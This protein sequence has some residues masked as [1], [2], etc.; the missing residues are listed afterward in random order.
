[1]AEKNKRES[2]ENEPEEK[3]RKKPKP[4]KE[5]RK[6]AGKF[7]NAK[8]EKD[9]EETELSMGEGTEIPESERKLAE[10][11]TKKTEK[12]LEK[13]TQEEINGT[14]IELN[15]AYKEPGMT[16]EGKESILEYSMPDTHTEKE[17]EVS[18]EAEEKQEQP[19]ASVTSSDIKEPSGGSEETEPEDLLKEMEEKGMISRSGD[20]LQSMQDRGDLIEKG[21]AFE[22]LKRAGGAGLA[23]E[24]LMESAEREFKAQIYASNEKRKER[25]MKELLPVEIQGENIK[26]LMLKLGYRFAPPDKGFEKRGF[27]R[28]I[29]IGWEKLFMLKLEIADKD[30]NRVIDPETKRPKLIENSMG[31]IKDRKGLIEF[32]KKE[33]EKKGEESSDLLEKM[34]ATGQIIERDGRIIEEGPITFGYAKE[35]QEPSEVVK[36]VTPEEAKETTEITEITGETPLEEKSQPDDEKKYKE[37]YDYMNSFSR[38]N[39]GKNEKDW[40]F[41]DA[42]VGLEKGDPKP[43]RKKLEEMKKINEKIL[44][45]AEKKNDAKLVSEREKNIEKLTKL[46]SELG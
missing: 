35:G 41:K 23:S 1:M 28:K 38:M 45:D 9:Y 32:L 40:E 25:K 30:G 21:D 26:F 7:K 44:K 17:E 11:N 10:E 4:K 31:G 3:P 34:K 46:L 13:E 6:E 14:I 22:S 27:F 42:L 33:Y 12:E 16:D 36:E 29:K 15:K 8:E 18:G 2:L 39:N 43:A 5:A 20:V 19:E 37:V 24:N